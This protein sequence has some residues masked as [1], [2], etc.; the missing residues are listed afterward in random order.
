[1]LLYRLQR[2]FYVAFAEKVVK[3]LALDPDATPVDQRAA[4]K[5][6][7]LKARGLAVPNAGMT[8][9]RGRA[10][11]QMRQPTGPPRRRKIVGREGASVRGRDASGCGTSWSPRRRN[12]P[13]NC[14]PRRRRRRQRKRSRRRA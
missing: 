14:R 6:K 10:A 3:G 12:R 1:M 9:D 13:T 8:T 7:D 11:F 2:D 5:L 4:D